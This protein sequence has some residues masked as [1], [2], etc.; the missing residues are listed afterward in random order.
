MGPGLP[1]GLARNGGH[2]AIDLDA[3]S[4]LSSG[5]EGFGHFFFGGPTEINSSAPGTPDHALPASV[6]PTLVGQ[7]ES[8]Y[9][10][11]SGV[12]SFR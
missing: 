2:Q 7:E 4:I 11:S 12:P 5:A 10:H 6:W 1:V 3:G 9:T 8:L